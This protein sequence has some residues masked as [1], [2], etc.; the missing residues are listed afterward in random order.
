MQIKIQCSCE[1][2]YAFDV[3]PVNGRM[4]VRANC[5]SCGADGTELANAF[6]QQELGVEPPPTVRI[7]AQS[8]PAPSAAPRPPAPPV[9]ESEAEPVPGQAAVPHCAKHPQEPVT[10]R[11]FVCQKPICPKCL[12]QFGYLCSV[13][14]QNQAVQR[15]LQVPTFAGQKTVVQQKERRKEKGL[16]AGAAVALL[17]VI[18]VWGWYSFV[19]SR[20]SALFSVQIP[21]SAAS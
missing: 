6:I 7:G 8:A 9:P 15:R 17:L 21:K 4:P 20:P 16:L 3:E 12:E 18:G 13:Y 5:P 10:A 19:G 2:R 1:T 14:C 11:C